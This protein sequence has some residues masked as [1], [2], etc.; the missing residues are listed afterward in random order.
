MNR[1]TADNPATDARKVPRESW[2][3]RVRRDVEP[4]RGEFAA[5]M[6]LAGIQRACMLLA[7]AG[8]YFDRMAI[9]TVDLNFGFAMPGMYLINRERIR[10]ENVHETADTGPAT[11][12]VA[13]NS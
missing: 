10:R 13:D 6:P 2:I 9:K 1:C 7:G 8:F 3:M 11:F 12:P 5:T 4:T